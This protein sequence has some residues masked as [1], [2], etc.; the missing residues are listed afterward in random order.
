MTLG[1][2][3]AVRQFQCHPDA[4]VFTLEPF[5]KGHQFPDATCSTS[6]QSWRECFRCLLADDVSK[7]L[8]RTMRH[9]QFP[10]SD[11]DGR[12]SP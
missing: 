11:R 8:G 4:C 7:L 10:P 2:A 3:I 5:S 6:L 9:S 1:Y 12:T